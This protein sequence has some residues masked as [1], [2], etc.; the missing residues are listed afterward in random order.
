MEESKTSEAQKRATLKW[1]RKNK[2]KMVRIRAKSAAK[3]YILTCNLD[4]IQIIQKWIEQ[5]ENELKN[6]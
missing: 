3:K 1:Q 5:R 6:N 2:D 4:E